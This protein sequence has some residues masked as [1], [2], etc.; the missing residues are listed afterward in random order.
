MAAQ[1]PETENDRAAWTRLWALVRTPWERTED[2]SQ[3]LG[4]AR[5]AVAQWATGTHR[6]PWSLLRAALRET[7]R[8]H[9]E[10]VPRLVE[11][12]AGEL[13]DGARGRWV[14]EE[15]LGERDWTDESTDLAV[16]QSD[17]HV[18][19]RD[20]DAAAIERIAQR[21]HREL[22]EVLAAARQTLRRV[23]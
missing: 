21:A 23:A 18:A 17:L 6:G 1:F 10:A 2:L 22:D 20:G 5:S 14:P 3:I 16:L 15:D 13:L 8:R 19:V 12:L 4:V 7:A 9:P 11:A